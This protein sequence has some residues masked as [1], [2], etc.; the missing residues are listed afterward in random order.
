MWCAYYRVVVRLHATPTPLLQLL[1]LGDAPLLQL[2]LLCDAPLLLRDVPTGLR[3][4]LPLLCPLLLRDVPP[5]LRCWLPLLRPL[6]LRDVPPTWAPVL[7]APATPAA[8]AG[9]AYW[10]AAPPCRHAW[11]QQW[12]NCRRHAA[13]PSGPCGSSLPPAG[14]GLGWG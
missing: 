5:G 8:A 4:W 14:G 2:L 11:R 1:L 3:C 13:R 7:A 6:L 10:S 12:Q 9:R